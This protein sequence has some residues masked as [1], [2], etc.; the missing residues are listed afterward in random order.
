MRQHEQLLRH[1]FQF[2]SG[3]RVV[4][5]RMLADLNVTPVRDVGGWADCAAV[6]AEASAQE[7]SDLFCARGTWACNRLATQSLCNAG[8][9]G[10][11]G[12]PT[13]VPVAAVFQLEVEAEGLIADRDAA[14]TTR[15]NAAHQRDIH[16]LWELWCESA[17]T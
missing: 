4:P 9:V 16:R 17:E 10:A 7:P 5:I 15:S 1:T 6:V 13:H 3:L 12:I 11:T 8:R 14:N 2:L